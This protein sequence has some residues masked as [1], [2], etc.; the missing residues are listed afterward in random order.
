MKLDCIDWFRVFIKCVNKFTGL[1]RP[2]LQITTTDWLSKLSLTY[3]STVASRYQSFHVLNFHT[4]IKS[5]TRIATVREQNTGPLLQRLW[6]I[7][8]SGGGVK[9]GRVECCWFSMVNVECEPTTRVSCEV[10]GQ[11]LCSG[12]GGCLLKL[13]AFSFFDVSW[14]QKISQKRKGT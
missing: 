9:M 2:Q 14:K 3:H 4:I 13:K 12:S 5:F 10:W 6:S 11:S 1:Q 8:I 7:K